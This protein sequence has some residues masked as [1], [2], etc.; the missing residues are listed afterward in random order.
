ML[1]TKMVNTIALK[2]VLKVI[3]QSRA[4]SIEVVA[5]EKC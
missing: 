2:V 3:K 1:L 5:A 4:V